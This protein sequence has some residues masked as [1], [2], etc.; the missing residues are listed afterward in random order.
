M[1]QTQPSPE[2][3]RLYADFQQTFPQLLDLASHVAFAPRIEQR[4][5]RGIRLRFLPQL[6]AL[7]ERSLWFSDLVAARNTSNFVFSPGMTTLL[8][9]CALTKLDDAAM[10]ALWSHYQRLTRHWKPLD[11]LERDLHFYALSHNNAGLS[12]VFR[13]L[14]RLIAGQ[15]ES[16]HPERSKL[17]DLA[18]RV[19][20][21][22][23]VLDNTQIQSTLARQL[24]NFADRSLHDPGVWSDQVEPTP[25]PLWMS[26]AIPEHEGARLS[27]D[28]GY[29]PQSASIILHFKQPGSSPHYIQFDTPLPAR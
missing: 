10:Q 6:D 27:V 13:D 28:I 23:S 2:D 12:M 14:L 4:L 17:L 26:N 16:T 1:S 8:T 11:R 21:A 20:Y 7:N 15:A 18:R 25:L 19:K 24:I 29:D 3:Q 9:Q 22:T 5:L